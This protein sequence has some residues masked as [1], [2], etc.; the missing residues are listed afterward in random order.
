MWAPPFCFW[1]AQRVVILLIA[2]NS[3][4][5][6]PSLSCHQGLGYAWLRLSSDVT[7]ST[8]NK[9]VNNLCHVYFQ[10]N[11]HRRPK[12]TVALGKKKLVAKS[13]KLSFNL[14]LIYVCFYHYKIIGGVQCFITYFTIDVA[15]GCQERGTV[16]Q[17]N[18][19]PKAKQ[20]RPC[21]INTIMNLAFTTLTDCVQN[22]IIS[23][24]MSSLEKKKS[25]FKLVVWCRLPLMFCWFKLPT[26]EKTASRQRLVIITCRI[27]AVFWQSHTCKPTV[28]THF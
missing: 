6:L 18:Q 12:V 4:K 16:S 19:A 14:C 13:L 28:E 27:W 9:R 22:Y 5:G 21:S 8:W 25:L 11:W 1:S 15:P 26:E 23:A 17:R 20:S 7:T 3:V 24:R 2:N 10:W